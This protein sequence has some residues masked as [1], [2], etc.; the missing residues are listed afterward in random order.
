MSVLSTL[1]K[2]PRTVSK[3]GSKVA[4]VLKNTFVVRHYKKI[5]VTVLIGALV[6]FIGGWIIAKVIS[7]LI[8]A[9]AMETGRTLFPDFNLREFLI[10]VKDFILNLF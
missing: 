8:F 5:L 7:N 9:A 2:I 1:K 6:I 4:N 10:E 3:F